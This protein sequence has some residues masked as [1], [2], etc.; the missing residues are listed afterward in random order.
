MIG[1]R[2]E[3]HTRPSQSCQARGDPL[4]AP[5]FRAGF[6][7]VCESCREGNDRQIGRVLTLCQVS[8]IILNEHTEAVS[9]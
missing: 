9:A 1:C 5:E 4:A 7:F 8:P 6:Q 2:R 3:P